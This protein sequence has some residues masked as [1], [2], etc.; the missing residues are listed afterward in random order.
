MAEQ[1]ALASP[2][3]TSRMGAKGP[4]IRIHRYR[5]YCR[6]LDGLGP[7]IGRSKPGVGK[8]GGHRCDEPCA[9]L[10]RLGIRPSGDQYHAEANDQDRDHSQTGED[11]EENALND[12]GL[13]S[14]LSDRMADHGSILKNHVCCCVSVVYVLNDF[15]RRTMRSRWQLLKGL[16]SICPEPDSHWPDPASVRM[17]R[18]SGLGIQQSSAGGG[19]VLQARRRSSGHGLCRVWALGVN[20]RRSMMP[21]VDWLRSVPTF[22]GS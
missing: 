5:S 9:L 7:G 14:L 22:A 2:I 13:P 3:A 15:S 1:A 18:Q 4:R 16:G 8:L 12:L 20:C 6:S 11:C 17:W 10:Q 21:S 19:L